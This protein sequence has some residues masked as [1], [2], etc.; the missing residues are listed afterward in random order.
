MR[1]HVLISL[2]LSLLT[3]LLLST[4]PLRAQPLEPPKQAAARSESPKESPHPSAQ[5]VAKLVACLKATPI[6]PTQSPDRVALYLLDLKTG[7]LVLIADEPEAGF[8]H[9]GS[10]TWSHDGRRILYDSTPGTQWALTHLRSIDI[11]NDHVVTTDLGTGNCPNFAP[12]DK[13]IAFL[14][15][16]NGVDRGVWIMNADGSKRQP[17][18]DYGRPR[19]SPDGRQLMVIAFG[20]PCSL[21]LMDANP[22]N[23]GPV[24]LDGLQFY[25]MPS[26]TRPGMI[27]AVLGTQDPEQIALVNIAKPGEAR[28][29]KTLF[30][31]S[32]QLDLQPLYPIYSPVTERYVFV[33]GKDDGMALYTFSENDSVPPRRL[34]PDGL[35]PL[36]ASLALSP[37]GRYLLFNSNRTERHSRPAARPSTEFKSK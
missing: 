32:T 17:L 13:R 30:K 25:T 27:V 11:E 21:T 15:N 2:P 9:C 33:G 8:T 7:E 37:D 5:A 16:A 18:G 28:I 26:W 24:Q 29:E 20:T 4:G 14:S 36:I 6:K 3:T 31:R 35:D 10:P 1:T 22:A 23:S 34:E 19:G 12:D